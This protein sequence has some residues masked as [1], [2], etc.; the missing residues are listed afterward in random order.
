M[1]NKKLE[2][3]LNQLLELVKTLK[4][5]S[6]EIHAINIKGFLYSVGRVNAL[7]VVVEL[8]LCCNAHGVSTKDIIERLE[9]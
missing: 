8:A 9:V 3:A 7:Q 5:T 1:G 2:K 6:D 4:L